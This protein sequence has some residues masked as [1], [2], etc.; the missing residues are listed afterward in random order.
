MAGGISFQQEFHFSVLQLF[1]HSLACFS[2]NLVWVNKKDPAKATSF[3]M[4]SVLKDVRT[5]LVKSDVLLYLPNC[6]NDLK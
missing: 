4:C 2:S 6:S 1:Y 5:G 3:S